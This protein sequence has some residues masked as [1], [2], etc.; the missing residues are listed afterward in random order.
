MVFIL[1]RSCCGWVFVCFFLLF[2][3]IVLWGS[4][5]DFVYFSC[6]SILGLRSCLNV[7]FGCCIF[8][9]FVYLFFRGDYF[10]CWI[11]RFECFCMVLG[12][13]WIFIFVGFVVVGFWC[14]F[15]CGW[16]F[17]CFVGDDLVVEKFF[18]FLKDK[19]KKLEEGGLVYSF[20]VEVVVKKFLG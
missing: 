15:V 10:G 16:Y 13:L 14:F 7:L 18:K 9:Y 3:I 5:G 6:V 20:F 12:V 2:W 19:N 1:L 17:L 11:L 4:L 8:I